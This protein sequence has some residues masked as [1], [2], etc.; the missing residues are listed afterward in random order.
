[1][2]HERVSRRIVFLLVTG[3]LLLPIA[4][5]AVVAVSALLG[6]MGDA[7]GALWLRRLAWLCG[8]LWLVD[9][10]CLVVVQALNS[11][12]DTDQGEEPR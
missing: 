10:V 4:A 7:D 3:V 9:L 2:A 6:A 8:A 1:M 11:L 5:W 12:S